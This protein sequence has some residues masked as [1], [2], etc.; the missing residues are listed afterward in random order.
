MQCPKITEGEGFFVVIKR[1]K[2]DK[3]RLAYIGVGDRGYRLLNECFTE[4]SDVEVRWLC[5]LDE[6]KVNKALKIFTDKGLPLPRV[7]KNYH[8][9]LSDPEVDAVAVM[10]GWNS[11]MKIT[12][13]SLHANKYTAMEVG[14][15]Y[16][17]SECFELLRAHEETGA[18]LMMLENC[19]YRRRAMTILKMVREGLFG[20]IVHCEGAYQ[21]DLRTEIL[22]GEEIRHYRLENYINRNCENYP[23]HELGPIAQ[24][25]NINRGNRMLYLTSMSSNP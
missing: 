12:L 19:C 7:T 16:D 13:D 15:A 18:P 6:E 4:M 9:A 17:I 2:R 5:E 8:E 23:T 1:E 21:H 25:L 24:I 3:V 10:T 14:C 20:E 22:R 11:H